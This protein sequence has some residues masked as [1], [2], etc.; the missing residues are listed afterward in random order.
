MLKRVLRLKAGGSVTAEQLAV[1]LLGEEPAATDDAPV[2]AVT[3]EIDSAVTI[4]SK[5]SKESKESNDTAS[6]GASIPDTLQPAD[7]KLQDSASP[8]T[9]STAEPDKNNNDA[10]VGLVLLVTPNENDTR[11]CLKTIRDTMNRVFGASMNLRAHLHTHEHA[12]T[13]ITR[14]RQYV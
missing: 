5:E 8:D 6:A 10:S 14:A 13:Q 4:E 2:S 11:S 7:T 1:A 12:P 3:I 9:D